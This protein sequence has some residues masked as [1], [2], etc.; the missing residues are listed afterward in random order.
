MFWCC[1]CF[2]NSRGAVEKYPP[3]VVQLIWDHVPNHWHGKCV[4]ILKTWTIL[5]LPG[6]MGSI[7]HVILTH[8]FCNYQNAKLWTITAIAYQKTFRLL[9]PSLEPKYWTSE[10]NFE[11]QRYHMVVQEL[12]EAGSLYTRSLWPKQL[13]TWRWHCIQQWALQGHI[14]VLVSVRSLFMDNLCQAKTHLFFYKH[15]KLTTTCIYA[16]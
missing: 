7:C 2:S 16:N 5:N 15:S 13:F 10:R 11:G 8:L 14:S 12:T 1:L 4:A 6:E 3:Y 9:C